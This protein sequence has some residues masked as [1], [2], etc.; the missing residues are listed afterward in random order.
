MKKRRG[1]AIASIFELVLFAMLGTM[2]FIMKYFMEFLPNIH[3]V[4][5][6]VAALT[7]VYRFKALI[8]YYVYV[9]INGVVGGFAAWW[10]PYLY[11]WLP[12]WA[13]VMAV[14]RRLRGKRIAAPVYALLCA[15][16]GALFGLLYT[17][18]QALLYGLDFK[19]AAAWWI[20]GLPFDALHA[21]GNYALGLLVVPFAALIQVLQKAYTKGAGNGIPRTDAGA[22]GGAFGN[23]GGDCADDRAGGDV[24]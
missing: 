21:V 2:L 14:S 16:H 18:A 23:G 24:S 19:A 10:I 7:V 1:A 17:P 4:A 6:F 11:I 12:L 15:V 20:A 9:M 8:P 3:P 5:L 13:A 22:P